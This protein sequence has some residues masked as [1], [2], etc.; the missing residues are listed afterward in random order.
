M[1]AHNVAVNLLSSYPGK[2]NYFW[3]NI[4]LYSRLLLP[5]EGFGATPRWTPFRPQQLRPG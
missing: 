4:L 5:M 3:R 1:A 2:K